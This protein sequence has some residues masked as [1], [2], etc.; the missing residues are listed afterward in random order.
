[1]NR[2]EVIEL[3]HRELDG[4]LT[5]EERKFLFQQLENDS[6]SR[7]IFERLQKLSFS[8][9]SLPKVTPPISIVDQLLPVLDQLE[10]PRKK[11]STPTP[12]AGP[13]SLPSTTELTNEKTRQK[14]FDMAT[15]KYKKYWIPGTV[16]AAALL[17][18]VISTG[19]FLNSPDKNME[20]ST[21]ENSAPNVTVTDQYGD[22]LADQ[23]HPENS[24]S[25]SMTM[26]V[27]TEESDD[28]G[29]REVND[30]P[31]SKTGNQI[32]SGG[33]KAKQTDPR[34]APKPDQKLSE[35][36]NPDSTESARKQNDTVVPNQEQAVVTSEEG[37]TNEGNENVGIMAFDEPEVIYVSPTGTFVAKLGPGNE[38]I[39]ID[40]DGAKHYI[41]KHTWDPEWVLEHIEWVT[42]T[43]LYYVLT[44]PKTGEKHYWIIDAEKREEIKL[45]NPYS[46]VEGSN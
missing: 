46:K 3:M 36:I 35:P 44:H 40:K 12:D 25:M 22:E 16:V 32:A 37:G 38:D 42:N 21:S 45:T 26:T 13:T 39:L 43:Q 41:S 19:D 5:V 33:G 14:R 8:L 2:E 7:A 30:T 23:A 15:W 9:E 11:G 6:E 28:T 4:D 29:Q 34:S 20:M 18:T 24:D 17:F 10:S 1:M 31:P 27:P